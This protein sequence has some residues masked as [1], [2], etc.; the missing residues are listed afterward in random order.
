MPGRMKHG[1]YLKPRKTKSPLATFMNISH[2]HVGASS[3]RRTPKLKQLCARPW[4]AGDPAGTIAF[5]KNFDR[6]F[7]RKND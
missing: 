1:G 2:G 7:G 4:E 6:I 5:K 3:N